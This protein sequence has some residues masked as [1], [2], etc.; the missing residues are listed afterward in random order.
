MS[1]NNCTI[2]S[3]LIKQNFDQEVIVL[4]LNARFN[5]RVDKL[6]YKIKIGSN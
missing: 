6:F 1:F 2:D 3:K 5:N 4:R